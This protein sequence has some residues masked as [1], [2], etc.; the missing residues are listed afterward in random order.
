MARTLRAPIDRL[1]TE[2]F[3]MDENEVLRHARLRLIKRIADAVAGFA[4]FDAME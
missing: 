2:V 4:R 1:F 3:V